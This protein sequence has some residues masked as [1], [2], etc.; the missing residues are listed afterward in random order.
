MPLTLA[1]WIVV[2]AA[3]YLVVGLVFAVPFVIRWVGRVDPAA[4]EGTV[5]FRLLVLPGT[6]LLWPFLLSRLVR[7]VTVP[8]EERNAHRLAARRS[9]T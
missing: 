9:P 7:G 5:G 8:P 2:G 6:V 3:G 4:R 1:S